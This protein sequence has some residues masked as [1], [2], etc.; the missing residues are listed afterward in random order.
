MEHSEPKE[1]KKEETVKTESQPTQLK[2]SPPKT[3]QKSI[4][5]FFT[6]K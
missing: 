5:S 6:R 2:I 4:M 1:T 3:K